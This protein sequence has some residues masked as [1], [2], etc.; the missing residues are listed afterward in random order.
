VNPDSHAVVCATDIDGVAACKMPVLVDI[1]GPHLLDL[2]LE[3]RESEAADRLQIRLGDDD[4]GVRLSLGF[5]TTESRIVEVRVNDGSYHAS[6][7]E[8]ERRPT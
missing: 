3:W 6:G 2:A 8:V 5:V 1:P 4:I 7:I